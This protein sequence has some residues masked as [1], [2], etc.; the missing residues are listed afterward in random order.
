MHEIDRYNVQR[1]MTFT[2]GFCLFLCH[3][4]VRAGV[5]T[6]ARDPRPR[7]GLG[8]VLAVLAYSVRTAL[9]LLM[10]ARASCV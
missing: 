2:F 5:F 4:F 6:P 3:V 10:R 8:V 1:G 7:L 9:L